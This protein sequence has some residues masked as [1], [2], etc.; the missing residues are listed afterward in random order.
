[1]T[2]VLDYEQFLARK[3]A[4]SREDGIPIEPSDINPMLKPHQRDIVQWAVRKGNAAIFAA[5]GLGK[6]Y[7][8]M[9]IQRLLHKAFGGKF[10][11]IAPLGV[12]QEF[13]RSAAKLGMSYRFIRR[14]DEIG[15]D[16]F[17][18]TNYESVRDGKLEVDGFTCAA[19]DEASVLRSYGSDTYQTFLALFGKVRFKFVATATP[20]PNRYKELIHYAAFLGIMDSGQALTRFFQRDST[21]ANN[22]TIYKHME[23]EFYLWL[24]SWAI[25]VQ[26]PKDLGYDDTG[27]NLPKMTVHYHMVQAEKLGGKMAKDGQ[28][29]LI[30]DAALGLKDAAEEKRNSIDRRVAKARE[31]L[32][33]SP[34][35]HFILWHDLEAERHAINDA[36]PDAV[37][38]Y[39]SQDLED[40]ED[41]IAA[42][43]E[44]RVQ[45]LST[46]PELAGSG[47][48]FQYHCH[49][50]I[51]VGIG[52]KFND[53]IQACHRIH[54]FQ[55]AQPVEI[56]IIYTETEQQIL[57]ALKE[58][59]AE[60][61]KLRL[62]MGE[63]I[64]K[65]GLSTAGMEHEMRRTIGATRREEKGEHF[66]AVHND[67]TYE[68]RAMASNSVDMICTSIP[69]GNHYEYS[70]SYND[71]GHNA[72]NATFFEQMDYL[73]PE[74]LRILRPGRIA[75]IH[76]K[77]RIQFGNVTG[78][79]MPS[80]EPFHVDCVMHYRKHG[81]I[82]MGM[83]TV[84]TDVVRENNQTYRLGWS[85]QCKDGTK[86]GVGSPEYILLFRK[87][88]TDTSRAYADVRVEKSK[89]EY[90]RAQWQID[91]HAF[92]RS[93]G[94]RLLT[95]D[96]LVN[97]PN[98]QIGRTFQSSSLSTVYDYL[99]HVKLG[100]EM[101]KRGAL[102]ATYMTL[103]P[104]SHSPDVWHDINR[105]LTL[106]GD[107]AQRGLVN[108]VCPLQIEIV[109]RLIGRYT[110][111]GEIVFDPFGGLGTVPYRA[112]M[113]GRYGIS[114]ELSEDYYADSLRYLR[115]AE[116]KV[117][118][119]TLFNL[120]EAE[121]VA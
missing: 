64:R 42:F 58:K 57:A 28:V 98:D 81:F 74:L 118:A 71:L 96:D 101:D 63:I 85:E 86:M 77:D 35:D 34:Q 1:M 50:A 121:A 18:I 53:F 87:L 5:F 70:P 15:E 66:T 27:Y 9:E 3:F 39:G 48:N 38:V 61:D 32:S 106:N 45:Y 11:I 73:T 99:E 113:T 91:A 36:I 100:V 56:H 8:T 14:T 2:T 44:G 89:E 115:A 49:K 110:N 83:I 103:A 4:F 16:D 24:H 47:C 90:T 88:P 55:Q 120:L 119:P 94:N 41:R 114:C 29:Q 13:I 104:G 107:Q 25:F 51:F 59:W 112:I 7:M 21:K 46:K 105:M 116:Q 33:E 72:D 79:G 54:R 30:N 22:L 109:D 78:Y 97:L 60:D 43:S 82:Y 76:T 52:Y 108:H 68:T 26:S 92:W 20:S 69:F 19:L 102:P 6:T 95:A 12:R 80:V 93:S 62:R 111:P 75:A 65:H 23:D 17:Y 84:V 67:S 40:R 10:L 37:D 117:S 31:I